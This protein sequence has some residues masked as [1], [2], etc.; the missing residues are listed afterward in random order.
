MKGIILKDL[1]DNF[2]IPKNAASFILA[3]LFVLPF[4]F[5][6]HSKY[7]YGLFAGV[8]LPLIGGCAAE[9]ATE[10]DEAANFNKLLITFPV[11]KA[12][13][14]TAKYILGFGFIAVTDLVALLCSLVQVYVH[15]TFR[16]TEALCVWGISISISLIFLSV[17]YVGYF[18]LGKRWGTIFFIIVTALIGAVYGAS[19]VVLGMDVI[20]NLSPLLVLCLLFAGVVIVAL[21][22][23]A[24]IRI[25][26]KKYS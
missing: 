8:I 17:I 24:S 16:L 1:Y 10:Q 5:L 20:F 9:A 13:I 22:R 18:L 21:S 23:L 2:C 11:T 26:K 12:E 14:V 6:T 7:Y 25:Y 19:S 3:A 15:H 4:G